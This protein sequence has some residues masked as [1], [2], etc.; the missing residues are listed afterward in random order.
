VTADSPVAGATHLVDPT[1][2]E[3]GGDALLD[4]ANAQDAIE[5]C[6]E[7]GWTD[8]LPVVPCSDA[9]L[10][11]FLREVDRDPDDIVLAMPHLN[12]SCTVRLAAINAAM[13]GCRP[14]YFPVVLAAWESLRIEGYAGKGIWQS[15][16]GTAPLLIVNGPVRERIGM[17]SQGNV[18]G[19]GFRAN[20]TIG[21]A[22]RLTALNTFG[23]RPRVLDQAT[24]G[25]PAKYT[26]SIAENQEESPWSALHEEHGLSDADSA[27]TALTMRSTI[28][29][30]ARHTAVAEQLLRD[31]AD[32]IARTGALLHET[33]SSCLVLC[34][35]HARLLADNGWDK[36]AIKQFLFE[37]ATC[38]RETLDRVGKGAVS[39]K[40]R[41]RVP[42]DH[43][44][45]AVDERIE[46]NGGVLH[47]LT[48]PDAV[49]VVVAGASNS[50]VSAVIDTF[51]PRG[52]SPAITRVKER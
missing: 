20:A 19:S 24:Q 47:V 6:F 9:L 5:Y 39:R 14:D 49:Q 23:L 11:S 45:A 17:N 27:V 36:P 30:E 41:W 13:A 2:N 8:G 50:G 35:E 40:T 46:Q 31:L 37:A 43:A 34:P 12:R 15:T 29:I 10:E 38:D 32:T 22:I 7:R 28:H 25:T 33:I 1:A 26:C 16:T 3:P 52:T 18:F 4:P 48:S 21:R 51:G 44:D 42:R